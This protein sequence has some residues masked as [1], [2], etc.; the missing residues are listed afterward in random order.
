MLTLPPR[1]AGDQVVFS[2]GTSQHYDLVVLATG[3]TDVKEPLLSIL[4]PDVGSRVKRVWGL[5]KEGELN[6]VWRDMG[7]DGLWVMVSKEFVL[8]SR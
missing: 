4:G 8:L 2:D 5:D 3:Y 7:V 6:G 1:F